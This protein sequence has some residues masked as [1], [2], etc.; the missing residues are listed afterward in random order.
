MVDGARLVGEGGRIAQR[1]LRD[2]GQQPN[3]AGRLRDAREPGRELVPVVLR[4]APIDEM[5]REPGQIEA[6]I[7]DALKALDELRSGKVG[8]NQNVEAE[9]V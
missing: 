4:V 2:R 1:D 7:L 6:E 5:I 8:Q 9:G 3:P